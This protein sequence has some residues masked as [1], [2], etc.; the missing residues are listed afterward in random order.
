MYAEFS[1]VS[2]LS[3]S[4]SEVFLVKDDGEG[5][6]LGI[7]KRPALEFREECAQATASSHNPDKEPQVDEEKKG[8]ERSV[9]ASTES[10]Q[11]KPCLGEFKAIDDDDGFKTPT[12]LDHKIPVIKQCPPAPRKPQPAP[13]PS[14]K[15]KASSSPITRRNLQVDL[16]L[17]IESLFPRPLLADLHRKVKKARNEDNH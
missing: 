2:V 3:M 15:R 1:Q 8:G 6:E 16:S 14:N 12:S 17:E 7:V 4:N 11:K 10:E 5:M 13:L 9:T